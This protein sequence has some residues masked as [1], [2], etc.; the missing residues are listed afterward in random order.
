[1]QKQKKRKLTSMEKKQKRE[2]LHAQKV[3]KQMQKDTA[4]TLRWMDIQSVEDDHI[5]IGRNQKRYIIKGIK[6]T[7]N[8]IFIN[9][10]EEQRQWIEGIRLCMNSAPSEM[11]FEF[12]YSPVNCDTWINDLNEQYL[13]DP[14]PSNRNMINADLEKI[15][16]FQETH[17]EKEFFIMIRNEDESILDKDYADL[18]RLWSNAGFQPKPLNKRDFYS[19]VAYYFEND[20]IN[21]YTFTRGAYSFLNMHYEYNE[22]RDSYETIDQTE[23][24]GA[25]GDP[26]A[27]KKPS[28]NMI[29]RSKI[30]PIGLKVKSKHLQLG[31]KYIQSL[32]V[33]K[34][35]E[36][37]GIGLLCDYLNN[38]KIKLFVKSSRL[39]M[40]M[41]KY[42]TKDLNDRKLRYEKSR[43]ETERRR[44]QQ[45]IES[46]RDYI[47]SVVQMN[48]KTHNLVIIFQIVTDSEVELKDERGKLKANLQVHGFNVT[49][50]VVMQESLF[51]VATPLFCDSGFD[52]VIEFN[53]GVPLT[54]YAVAGLYPWIYETLNDPKGFLIGEEYQNGGKIFLDSM[55]YLHNPNEA[56][57]QNRLN[58]NV[59]VVGASGSGKTTA[60]SM[61]IR[62]MIEKKI[63]CIWVDPENKNERLTN[64]NG[65]IYIDWGKRG[66][67][68]NPFDLKPISAEDDDE[69]V[70]WDTELAINNVIEDVTNIF[71]FLFPKM[72]EDALTF[73]GPL[74]KKTYAKAGIKR[75]AGTWTDF[76]YIAPDVFPTFTDFNDVLDAEIKREEKKNKDS[77]NLI[78]LNELSRRMQRIM[79]EWGV[80][81]NGHTTIKINGYGRKIVSFGTKKLYTASEELQNAL[82]Y[83]M[84]TY[85]WSLCL[86]DSYESAFIVDEAQSVIQRGNTARLLA[87]FVR[88]SRKYRNMMVIGT[89]EPHDFADQHIITDGKAIFN[90]SAYKLVLAM[91]HDAT[92]DLSKLENLNENEIF[93]I[94]NFTQGDALLII[95]EQRRLTIHV[96]PSRAE[97]N[98][99]GAMF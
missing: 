86:D 29:Q 7:P 44:I 99:M 83:I 9:R 6:L 43:D 35:P 87:Q 49:E 90:N 78:F 40:N 38:P 25:Y 77:T 13:Q 2:L 66:N 58:G 28:T 62:Q 3:V 53:I 37:Y 85:A 45:E 67:I 73:V 30:A 11:W 81:F 31:D 69:E 47:D 79:N 54:S 21:D 98:D 93:W 5:I 76:R 74:V 39:N 19:L 80:Y 68:I 1:M 20:L 64:L 17:R 88:R 59:I 14:E 34:L 48:D 95:G 4:S 32:L 22:E 50:G 92:R 10:E 18:L 75:T 97:L 63:T 33:T 52:P 65:G 23:L 8:N 16:A 71:S 41:Q 55:Y 61:M 24:F 72:S 51:K 42:L 84:F 27:N 70:V 89:Q 12:V 96:S 36:D 94:E 60:M 57:L 26:I 82:Y 46:Q 15:Y 91:N 56:K